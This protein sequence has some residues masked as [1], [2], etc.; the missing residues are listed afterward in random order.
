MRSQTW[1]CILASVVLLSALRVPAQIPSQLPGDATW[2]LP[3]GLAVKD[4]GPR[5]YRFVVDYN[6]ANIKGEILQRQR[7]SGEYI[8]GLPGGEVM[9]KNVTM[10]VAEGETAPLGPAQKRDFMEGFRYRNS[11]VSSFTDFFK[12]FPPT[13]IVERNLV[14]DTGMIEMFGQNYFETLKLNEPYHAI[15][16]QSTNMPGVGTFHN[17][18]VTLEWVG[19]SR[20]NGEL[21]A[22]IEYR[23]FL[24]P[25]A[26]A[27]AGM[28]MKARSDYWGQIWVSL[29]TKQVE[30]ATL[31]E[32]VIGEMQLPN[33]SAPQI[34]NVFRSGSLEPVGS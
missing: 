16:N 1:L 6:S 11:L 24:N 2:S 31:Y 13:A 18:D 25:I 14:W 22:V 12:G 10:A 27:T 32:T 9:W 8:R 34:L 29:V 17:R 26:L 21:C 7:L 23:A 4:A 30:Y 19:Y 20:R 5:T 28:T 33:Q 3:H 15:S